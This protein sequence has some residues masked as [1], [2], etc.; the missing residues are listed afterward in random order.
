MCWSRVET[1]LCKVVAQQELS[2]APLPRWPRVDACLKHVFWEE[3]D[4]S[5]FLALRRNRTTLAQYINN[6]IWLG[7]SFSFWRWKGTT[8]WLHDWLHHGLSSLWLHQGISSFLG[9]TLAAPGL[10]TPS[11]PYISHP[12]GSTAVLAP[13]QSSESP[14]PPRIVRINLGPA[15]HSFLIPPALPWSPPFPAPTWSTIWDCIKTQH[16]H[17]LKIWSRSCCLVVVFLSVLLMALLNLTVMLL[18]PGYFHCTSERK[19]NF[20][21]SSITVCISHIV[22]HL[23]ALSVIHHYLNPGDEF[24][25]ICICF[26]HDSSSI[27]V[28]IYN[29]SLNCMCKLME[30][31]QSVHLML[32]WK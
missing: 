15:L 7:G 21:V 26:L 11:A 2:F 13:P 31:T 30:S 12:S 8:P 9:S 6:I 17:S 20:Q 28:E 24:I 3:V 19:K 32:I 10:Y 18:I 23:P 29:L 16:A 14:A 25:P 27:K 1:K 5:L 22:I 4:D